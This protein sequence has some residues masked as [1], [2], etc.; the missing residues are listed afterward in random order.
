MDIHLEVDKHRKP[1]PATLFLALII[2]SRYL[3]SQGP[4]FEN[5]QHP[6]DVDVMYVAEHVRVLRISAVTAGGGNTK[7]MF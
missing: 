4:G 2:F 6:T 7:K 3:D 1:F 5:T